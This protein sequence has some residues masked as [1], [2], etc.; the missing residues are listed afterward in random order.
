[1]DVNSQLDTLAALFMRQEAW[2]PLTRSLVG[3]QDLCERFGEER[4]IFRL[5][6]FEP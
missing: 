2:Y 4:N 1:M 6:V 3:V 5:S